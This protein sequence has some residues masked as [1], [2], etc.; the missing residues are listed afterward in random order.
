MTYPTNSMRMGAP[1]DYMQ[2]RAHACK[3]AHENAHALHA[4]RMRANVACHAP[5][6]Q[7]PAHLHGRACPCACIHVRSGAHVHALHV[8]GASCACRTWLCG[9]LRIIGIHE[10]RRVVFDEHGIARPHLPRAG[11]MHGSAAWMDI[12][13]ERREGVH[14]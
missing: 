12:Q 4:K 11:R 1:A 8:G 13:T 3:R 14:G 6:A 9:H 7:V 5:D 10:L 2:A